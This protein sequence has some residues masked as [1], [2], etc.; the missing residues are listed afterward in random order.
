MIGW[1]IIFIMSRFILFFILP[2]IGWMP[3]NKLVTCWICWL[4]Q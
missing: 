1:R 3:C 4:Y 2:A